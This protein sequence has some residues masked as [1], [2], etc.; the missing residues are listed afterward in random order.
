[1]IVYTG[2]YSQGPIY[3][4]SGLPDITSGDF[5][6]YTKPGLYAVRSSNNVSNIK[7][8]PEQIAGILKVYS[9]N[10]DPRTTGNWLYLKQEFSSCTRMRKYGRV[11]QNSSDGVWRFSDW[12]IIYDK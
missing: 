3:T 7:N 12:T 11:V 6:D 1:M 2:T 5:N 4:L 10:G 9:S 8:M